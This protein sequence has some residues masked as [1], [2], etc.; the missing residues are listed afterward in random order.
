MKKFNF[1]LLLFFF[2]SNCSIAQYQISGQLIDAK[3]EPLGFANIVLSLA[4]DSSFLSGTTSEMDGLFSLP[5]QD[6]NTY[7]ITIS[8]IGFDN[9]HSSEIILNL[10]NPIIDLGTITLLEGGLKLTEVE[11][12]AR[13]PIFERKIDRTVINLE[14]RIATAGASALEVLEQSPGVVVNRSSGSIGM[15]GKDGVNVMI[16]GKLNYMPNDALLQFLGG[17]DANN[18]L[19]IELITTPPANFD[20]QGNAGFINIVLK[21]NTDEGLKGSY[22]LTGGY[23]RG[24]LGNASINLNYRKGKINLFG[25]Y[26]YTY[27]G[28][29]QFTTL[30]R[31]IGNFE[32]SLIFDREPIRNNQNTSLGLDYQVGKNTTIGVLF[33]GYLNKWDMNALNTITQKDTTETN[34][35][36]KNR[37]DNDWQHLQ[38]NF[39]IVH[40]FSNGGRLST[41]FDYLY[42]RNENPTTYDQRFQDENGTTFKELDLFST[43]ITPFNIQVGKVDYSIPISDDFKFAIGT[44]Y[45]QSNFENDV[46]V[47]ENNITLTEFVSKSDLVESVFAAYTDLDYQLS[48]KVRVKGG[49]RYEYTN[50]KLNSTNGGKVV[51]RQFGALFPS[52]FFNYKI[53]SIS[54]LNLSYSKRINRPSFSS[55]APFIFFLTPTTSFGGNAALQPAIANTFQA[56]YRFK[57]VNF[58]IQYTQEDSTIAGFQNRFDPISNTQLII[59]DNLKEQKTLSA[60][61][62]FPVKVNDWWN[63]RFFG[64]YTRQDIVSIDDEFGVLEFGQNFFRLNGSQ[65]FKLPKNFNIELSGFYQSGGLNGNVKFKSQNIFNIGIQKKLK[66]EAR[67]TFN[68]NDVFNSLEFTGVTNLPDEN[69]FV[70]RTFDFSQRTFRLTYSTTFGNKKVKGNRKRKSGT[71][72]KRRVN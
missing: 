3:N 31:T 11:V 17:M 34:I 71:D 35:I 25:N 12:V 70:T 5:I 36:S 28:Q 67:L 7:F 24:L 41:D 54:Q 58:S 20:A 62:A 68:I 21:R 8:T 4:S 1:W 40:Q 37:E 52:L 57:T 63:M 46:L 60:S 42:Y 72:E 32:T 19:K 49:L 30:N 44:K 55:M 51:D 15:L 61:I 50:T 10:Q 22:A 2:T 38:S 18:I 64:I 47:E 56:D 43:K 66:N 29:E 13:K 59:P 53:N 27:N 16:N 9:Y 26:A 23:G 33:S 69:V 39:N 65:S 48:E 14:N 6:A 45:V